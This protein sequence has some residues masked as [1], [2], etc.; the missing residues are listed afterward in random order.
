M[1]RKNRDNQP[2]GGWMKLDN[3]A[4]IYPAVTR[5]ELTGV[6][7]ISIVLNSPV[8][9]TALQQAVKEASLVFPSFSV[10]LCR[11]FFWYYL[12]Y[13]GQPPRVHIDE[14]P[15]CQA[16]PKS[17]KGEVMYRILARG[18]RIS[19][20]FL[21]IITDGGGAMMYFKTLLNIYHQFSTSNPSA[22]PLFPDAPDKESA[23]ETTDLFK[24]HFKKNFPRPDK[25]A[26]AW[27][28]PYKLQKAP[29]FR[30]IS[31]ILPTDKL[32][33]TAKSFNST[34]T[35]FLTSVYLHSLQELRNREKR[36][37]LHIRV[38]VPVDL[39][40]RYDAVTTRNFSVFVM[41]E[42]DMRMGQYSFT[43]ILQEVKIAVGLMTNEKRITKI[44]SRNVSGEYNPVVRIIPL[45]LKSP[46]LRIAYKK[47]GISQFSGVLTNIGK[48]EISETGTHELKLLFIIP[49]PPDPRVKV[50]CGIATLG[51]NTIITFGSVTGNK[52]LE[53]SF[54]RFLTGTGIQ[55][56]VL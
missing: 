36:G 47:F 27:H 42:I 15:P 5:G 44:I 28:L 54:M 10:E 29:R 13:N 6:F 19:A 9:I 22:P 38:Q 26:T 2:S 41:P 24:K 11:G 20:E 51:N 43:E 17:T 50:S 31:F 40:R 32:L 4:K 1:T 49:P 21:H 52:S 12:E 55:A 23:R 14:G 56:K 39:R 46:V 25:L 18:N 8:K 33:G 7:R 45:F 53:Q 30:T 35:E 3:A 34:I 48:T 16:F 37:S